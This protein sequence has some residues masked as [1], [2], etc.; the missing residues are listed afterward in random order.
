MFAKWKAKK[1]HI[2][3]PELNIKAPL[4]GESVPLREVP[5]PAFAGGHMGRGIA[6]LPESGVLKA[7]FDGRVA[8]VVKSG[9]AVILEHDTGLQLLL[10]IGIDTV[11]LK[12]SAFRPMISQGDRVTEG[13]T[14]IEFDISAIEAAGCPVITPVI[15]TGDE[16]G[17]ITEV[18]P[19]YGQ[20][21]AGLDAVL[22][23]NTGK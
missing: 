8:H 9:H 2:Q 12:G 15:I 19:S 3:P 1:E 23:V 13:Q 5:D 6:I 4:T 20:V 10:H 22:T 17:N 7:P 16:A 18:I 21:A 14:L 11:K